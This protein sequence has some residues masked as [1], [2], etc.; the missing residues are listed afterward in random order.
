MTERETSTQLTSLPWPVAGSR[1]TPSVQHIIRSLVRGSALRQ[2]TAPAFILTIYIVL[3]RMPP[4]FSSRPSDANPVPLWWPVELLVL[5][6]TGGLYQGLGLG[7]TGLLGGLL[8]LRRS[9]RAI[10]R[11]WS[12]WETVKTPINLIVT[13]VVAVGTTFL[14]TK[15]DREGG[16]LALLTFFFLSSVGSLASQLLESASLP[17]HAG[18]PDRVECC[19][20]TLRFGTNIGLDAS[21]SGTCSGNHFPMLGGHTG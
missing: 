16:A 4:L 13:A 15:Y 17:A 7:S 8:L 6:G 1:R 12:P 18:E 20:G 5:V 21:P 9:H 19:A 2:V 10:R 3:L 11:G 14:H